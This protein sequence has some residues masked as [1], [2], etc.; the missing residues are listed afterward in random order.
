[1]QFLNTRIKKFYKK[2]SINNLKKT[3]FL[4]NKKIVFNAFNIFNKI[5]ICII[6]LKIFEC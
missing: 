3:I 6:K 4:M 1:M 5:S 2:L